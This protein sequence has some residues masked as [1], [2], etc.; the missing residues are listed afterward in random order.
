MNEY[1]NI[2]DKCYGILH[3]KSPITAHIWIDICE[4]DRITSGIFGV[5]R[6]YLPALRRLEVYGFLVSSENQDMIMIKP[7]CLKYSEDGDYYC[8]GLCEK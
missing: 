6:I 4:I 7:T 3:K 5:Q 8:G 2:C 1:S